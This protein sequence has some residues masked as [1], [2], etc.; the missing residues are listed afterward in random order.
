MPE[1]PRPFRRQSPQEIDL[2]SAREPPSEKRLIVV[3]CG[4]PRPPGRRP[5]AQ[6]RAKLQS[7]RAL[8]EASVSRIAGAAAAKEEQIAA[9]ARLDTC[10]S[11]LRGAAQ[12]AMRRAVADGAAAMLEAKS[13]EFRSKI[14]A[15]ASL[16]ARTPARCRARLSPLSHPMDP[17]RHGA[18][19]SSTTPRRRAGTSPPQ[20]R[21]CCIPCAPIACAISTPAP[22]PHQATDRLLRSALLLHRGRDERRAAANHSRSFQLSNPS[23][24]HTPRSRG[25]LQTPDPRKPAAQELGAGVNRT[26][27]GTGR[28]GPK[29]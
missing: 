28:S 8:A 7:L 13:D 22:H 10:R 20:A 16:K 25:T 12:G 17:R 1:Q 29:V 24:F 19:V 23:L 4:T 18:S 21:G 2:D 27:L 6:A 5:L 3:R 9:E 26:G 14:E 11:W 15:G